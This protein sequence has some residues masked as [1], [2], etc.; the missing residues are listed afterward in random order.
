MISFTGINSKCVFTYGRARLLFGSAALFNHDGREVALDALSFSNPVVI[1]CTDGLDS[2]T[3]QYQSSCEEGEFSI[4][5]QVAFDPDLPYRFRVRLVFKNN[6]GADI[7]LLKLSPILAGKDDIKLGA[8]S[9][10]EWMLYRQGRHKNDMPSVCTLGIKDDRF[11]DAAGSMAESG[12]GMGNVRLAPSL[13]SDQLTVLRA[14]AGDGKE[15]I[16]LLIGFLTGCNQLFEC[17]IKLSDDGSLSTLSTGCLFNTVLPSGSEAACEWVR[18]DCDEDIFRAIECYARD[19]ALL[20]NARKSAVPPSVYLT[21]FHYG[22]TVTYDDIII[23]LEA[24]KG[25]KIPFDVFQIDE[26]WEE[27]LG[28]WLPNGKFPLGMKHTA[29]RIR[30]YGF[31]PGI[32]TSPFVVWT[33]GNTAAKHPDWLLRNKDGSMCTFMWRKNY[34]VLDITNPEVLDWIEQLYRTLARDWGYEYHKLDFTRAPAECR[35]AVFYNQH[36]TVAQAYRNAFEIIRRGAGEKAFINICG[37][38]YDPVIGVV[39][40]QVTCSD[41]LGMWELTAIKGKA[42]PFTIKQNLM[43]YWMNSLWDNNPSAMLVRRQKETVRE[44][45][46]SLGL[47]NDEE[48]KTVAL[49]QYF[50]GGMVVST[51]PFCDISDDRIFLLRHV[52]PVI[53]VR[54][55]PRDLFSGGRYPAVIDCEV[56]GKNGK[57][58][59]TVTV[60]N[61]SDIDDL[62]ASLVIGRETL[63]NYASEHNSFI[64]SEFFSGK[65]GYGLKSGDVF[66]AGVI[67]PH[68]SAH[69]KVM[70]SSG[71]P[72]VV[73]SDGHFSMG[74]E[75]SK[76]QI[77]GNCLVFET[78]WLFS[79]PVNYIIKLPEDITA[80]PARFPANITM[81]GRLLVIQIPGDGYYSQNIPL[82]KSFK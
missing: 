75:I 8:A 61:W 19:K 48:V 5:R 11:R 14:S 16:N 31:R 72:A 36:I 68:G 40:S 63:G 64:V 22:S 18:I 1:D 70:P 67:K 32:W 10:S 57:V 60:I 76:L 52:M 25:R 37:G 65:T 82:I 13:T 54:T 44:Q 71:L 79:Y 23:E 39:D 78:E 35:N 34:Y 45:N 51:E 20:Y 80:D 55:V 29:D 53:K 4:T 9:S 7:R 26:G 73:H 21:W 77:A 27:E 12:S 56:T 58:W 28:E 41:A 47:F 43:R 6:A 17:V 50:G 46:L 69:F 59:H 74:G 62:D 15:G 3:K 30:S 2:C 66:R 42:A 81:V 33:G 38:L 49:N 24:L